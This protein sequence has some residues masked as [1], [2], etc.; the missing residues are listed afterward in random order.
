MGPIRRGDPRIMPGQNE[1][2]LGGEP[3]AQRCI[4]S[5]GRQVQLRIEVHRAFKILRIEE[6]SP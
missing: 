3:R 2:T 1:S 4:A 5:A 6:A